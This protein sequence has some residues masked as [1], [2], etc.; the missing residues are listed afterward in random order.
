MTTLK[1]LNIRLYC[2]L[3]PLQNPK[4]NENKEIKLD[5]HARNTE[6]LGYPILGELDE[7]L[8]REVGGID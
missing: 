2:I 7:S 1:S 5:A 8:R 4:H 3:K 6:Q